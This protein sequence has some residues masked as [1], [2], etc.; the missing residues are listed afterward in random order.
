MTMHFADPEH[1]TRL[2][3]TLRYIY[4]C[5]DTGCTTAQLQAAT[6]W[7]APSTDI[8]ELRQSGYIIERTYEGRTATGRQ[9]N[10]YVYKGRIYTP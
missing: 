2:T 3:R 6:A 1:S 4:H 5:A 9:I 7:M 10:R 8:S